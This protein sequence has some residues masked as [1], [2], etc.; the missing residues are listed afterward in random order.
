[1][2]QAIKE[3]YEKTGKKVGIKPAGGISDVETALEYYTIVESILGEEWLNPEKFRIG[4]S[5][6][7][8]AI[9]AMFYEKDEDFKYF[10]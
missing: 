9:L 3:Y 2:C 10:N 4:A 6:L 8:N 7:A 5:R 1:M